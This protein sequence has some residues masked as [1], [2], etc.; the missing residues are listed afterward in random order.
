MMWAQTSLDTWSDCVNVKQTTYPTVSDY[1][2]QLGLVFLSSLRNNV[3]ASPSSL[4]VTREAIADA[5]MVFN[6]A[7]ISATS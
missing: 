2:E 7:T 6:N 1:V 5:K 4:L 3:V